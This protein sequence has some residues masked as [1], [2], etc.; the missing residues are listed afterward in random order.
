MMSPGLV[1]IIPLALVRFPA[2]SWI[3]IAGQWCGLILGLSRTTF[4]IQKHWLWF[5]LLSML[6]VQTEISRNV[7]S[8]FVITFHLHS[9]LARVAANLV[10][11]FGPF[12]SCVPFHFAVV[13]GFTLVGSP[14]NGTVLIDHRGQLL[15]G[16]D[17]DFM[18]GSRR[19]EPAKNVSKQRQNIERNLKRRKVIEETTV[20]PLGMTYLE[21][22]SVKQPT[23]ADYTRRHQEFMTWCSQQEIQMTSAQQVDDVLVEFLQYLFDEDRGINDGIRVV[24][25]TKFFMP[26]FKNLPRVGRALRGWQIASPPLQR[27]PIPIEVLCAIIG[28]MIKSGLKE[29]GLRLFFQF[30]TYLRPG[31]C[32]ALTVKQV[33]PPVRAANQAFQFWAVLLHPFEDLVPGKTGVFDASII[34]DSDAWMTKDRKSV[35]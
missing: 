32:S 1:V 30:I 6:F 11:Y 2:V 14:P 4:F 13:Q 24:A 20:I 16:H 19:R 33:V 34:L 18:A 35:V 26:Q 15:S 12:E 5:G 28:E 9:V 21:S 17:V 3:P 23:I 22:R 27:M 8:F 7:S 10:T 31:E 25:A 29:M